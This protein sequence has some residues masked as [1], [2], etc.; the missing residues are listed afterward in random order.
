VRAKGNACCAAELYRGTDAHD[1]ENDVGF[2]PQVVTEDDEP[3]AVLLDRRGGRI[4]ERE[5][6]VPL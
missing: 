3:G 6:P 4:W 5:D 1:D 2:F